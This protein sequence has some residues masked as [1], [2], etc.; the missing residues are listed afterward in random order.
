MVRATTTTTRTLGF[1][2][3]RVLGL[4]EFGVYAAHGAC[5]QGLGSPK[6]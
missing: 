1:R 4:C 6:P 2:V 3:S 5:S